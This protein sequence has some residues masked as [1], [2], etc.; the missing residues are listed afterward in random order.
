MQHLVGKVWQLRMA[1][2]V[3]QPRSFMPLLTGLRNM[4]LLSHQW[5]SAVRADNSRRFSPLELQDVR[6]QPLAPHLLAA[7]FPFPAGFKY[8]LAP[9]G[10][11]PMQQ[12]R[13]GCIPML[14]L[15]DEQAYRDPLRLLQSYIQVGDRHMKTRL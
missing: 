3:R 1:L 2:D 11:K 14:V 10:T 15:R 6:G 4:I 9:D 7:S 5:E 13:A 12:R 8:Q